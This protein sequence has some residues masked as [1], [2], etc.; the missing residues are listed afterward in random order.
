MHT[1]PSDKDSST[2]SPH[3]FVVVHDELKSLEMNHTWSLI[4]LPGG[5]VPYKM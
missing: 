2:Q 3:W 4:Y 5:R 1:E